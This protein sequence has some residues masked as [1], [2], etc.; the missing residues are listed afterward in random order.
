MIRETTN[1]PGQDRKLR[2]PCKVRSTVTKRKTT[3]PTRAPRKARAK[4]PARPKKRRRPPLTTIAPAL[5]ERRRLGRPARLSREMIAT[6]VEH[7]KLGLPLRECGALCGALSS[8]VSDWLRDGR[9]DLENGKPTIAAEFS[10]TVTRALAELQK[11]CLGAH[12]VYQRMAEGWKPDCGRCIAKGGPCG[13]HAK[14]LRLAADLNWRM[15]THRFARD[16]NASTVRHE[17][18]SGGDDGGPTVTTPGEAGAGAAM[19]AG[20][21]VFIPKRNDGT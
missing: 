15:L 11:Q 7:L 12:L 16:W 21:V 2:S 14:N 4:S 6:F 8:Q 3:K 13:K 5:I 1:R 17:L 20:L 19:V 10:E 9:R 18:G